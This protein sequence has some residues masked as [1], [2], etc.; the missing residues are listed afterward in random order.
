MDEPKI[1]VCGTDTFEVIDYIPYGYEFWNI[2]KNMIDGY[3]PLCRMSAVQPFPGA[4]CIDV[5]SLK[6]IK[7]DGAQTVLAASIHGQTTIEAMEKYLE[8]YIF[9]IATGTTMKLE[10]SHGS[11]RTNFIPV[12]TLTTTS[13]SIRWK[14]RIPMDNL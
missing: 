13:G 1:I 7:L 12:V 10:R 5:D 3:L 4:R 11:I 6:A 8:R 2:G 14:L 9:V